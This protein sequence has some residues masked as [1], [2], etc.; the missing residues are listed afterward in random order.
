MT[1]VDSIRGR[2]DGEAGR[3]EPGLVK[4]VAVVEVVVEVVVVVVVVIMIVVLLIIIIVVVVVVIVI[5]IVVV[6]V[7]VVRLSAT[8][9]SPRA[10]R[11]HPVCPSPRASG[12][13]RPHPRTGAFA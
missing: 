10:P 13:S 9:Y 3:A 4:V 8:L 2:L 12:V 7:V 11:A 5:V 6:V 1:E